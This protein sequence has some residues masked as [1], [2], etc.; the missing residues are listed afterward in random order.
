MPDIWN[1]V[2]AVVLGARYLAIQCVLA[3]ACS[4]M[5]DTKNVLRFCPYTLPFLARLCNFPAISLY[6]F[7]LVSCTL[8]AMQVFHI[9]LHNI[10][11]PYHMA[12]N[13]YKSVPPLPPHTP[14]PPL[15]CVT[16]WLW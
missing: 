11:K 16:G 13:A 10:H 3:I 4:T 14:W 9:L 6:G 1:G 12:V 15:S 7:H 5:M 2:Q 8:C